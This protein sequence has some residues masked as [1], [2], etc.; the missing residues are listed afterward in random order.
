M[1]TMSLA[2]L[3]ELTPQRPAPVGDDWAPHPGGLP[4]LQEY[5]NALIVQGQDT[6]A[7]RLKSIPSPWARPL[8]FAQALTNPKHPAHDDILNEWRGL[9]GCI[10]LQQHLRVEVAVSPLN[11]NG[12]NEEFPAALARLAPDWKWTEIA[13]LWVGNSV[14]GGISPLTAVFTGIRPVPPTIPFQRGG[15]LVDPV[16]HFDGRDAV[17]IELMSAWIDHTIENISATDRPL[18]GYVPD[19]AEIIGLLRTWSREAVEALERLQPASQSNPHS[20]FDHGRLDAHGPDHP[21]SALAVFKTI[22]PSRDLPTNDLRLSDELTINPGTRG[23]ILKDGR[24]YNGP[25]R[26]PRGLSQRVENGRLTSPLPADA[27]DALIDP[28]RYVASRL[29]RV[30]GGRPGGGALLPETGE[31][32]FLFPLAA[33]I[34]EYL[35]PSTLLESARIERSGSDSHEFTLTLDLP[36]GYSVQ[37]RKSYDRDLVRSVDVT[38]ALAVWPDFQSDDWDCYLYH[39]DHLRDVE[40]DLDLEPAGGSNARTRSRSGRMVW[41]RSSSPI[42][43]WIGRA[44]DD[45]G[46]L[47]PRPLDP[48][49]NPGNRRWHLSVDFGSTHTRVFHASPDIG[50]HLA[51]RPLPIHP[52]ARVLLGESGWSPTRVFLPTTDEQEDKFEELKSIVRFPP[53][54]VT[55]SDTEGGWLPSQGLIYFSDTS[56][57]PLPG[58]LRSGLKWHIPGSE[59]E[60]AFTSYLTQL[61]LLIQAEAAHAGAV[62]ESVGVAHPSAFEKPRFDTFKAKWEHLTAS[63]H[64]K[65]PMSE[66]TAL[67]NFLHGK[68]LQGG[69]ETYLAAVDIG[70]STSDIALW[71][72]GSRGPSTSIRWAGEMVSRLVATDESVRAALTRAMR[73]DHLGPARR[74]AVSWSKTDM[75]ENELVFN[76]LLRAVTRATGT[77]SSLAPGLLESPDAGGP[78]LVHHI[79]YLFSG[80]AFLMGLLRRAEAG[81]AD[82]HYVHVGGLGSDYYRWLEGLESNAGSALVSQFFLAG[83]GISTDNG[84]AVEV[85][86]SGEQ[87]K[88]EVGMGLLAPTYSDPEKLG[89]RRTFVGEVGFFAPDGSPV[90][91]FEPIDDG[92]LGRRVARPRVA[93]DLAT[94]DHFMSFVHTFQGSPLSRRIAKD[95]GIVQS[96]LDSRLRDAITARQFGPESAW[97]RGASADVCEPLVVSAMKVLLEH[98]TSNNHLFSH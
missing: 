8:L 18:S 27:L 37:I 65:P 5:A 31:D 75:K 62:V 57:T 33:E 29:I 19:D 48:P 46:L 52:R 39:I 17:S 79:A 91:P 69:V 49:M 13:L 84:V 42:R 56:T 74:G 24:P 64:L 85:S 59:D 30:I 97:A 77:A 12:R 76:G 92:E 4:V 26:L 16:R 54:V 61:M 11:L 20:G 23:L 38:P 71:T 82:T 94:M 70:G 88:H 40:G 55:D 14:I 21:T 41:G 68:G 78:R 63:T 89:V 35:D 22:R 47:I 81:S 50:D 95:L 34:L 15:R 25:L 98:V 67:A 86:T 1:D 9:L 60:R 36:S 28:G 53:D 73:A 83:A 6:P 87:A 45:V 3:P 7:E 93:R 44:G 43:A 66:A 51:K 90:P 10:A 58:G 32:G 2:F 72:K 80:L 96:A